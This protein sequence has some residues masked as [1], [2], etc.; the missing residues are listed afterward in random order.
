MRP[1]WC[2]FWLYGALW[3]GTVR[4]YHEGGLTVAFKGTLPQP[5][6]AFL[7]YDSLFAPRE[8]WRV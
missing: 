8:V 2:Y 1:A 3:H 7:P 6:Y 5:R 4:E